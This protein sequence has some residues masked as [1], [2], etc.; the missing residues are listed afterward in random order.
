MPPQWITIKIASSDGSVASMTLHPPVGLVNLPK[1]DWILSDSGR[2][3]EL[4]DRAEDPEIKRR[5]AAEE[6]Y[7]HQT[8]IRDKKLMEITKPDGG[9]EYTWFGVKASRHDALDVARKR[10]EAEKKAAKVAF[11]TARSLP[12]EPPQAVSKRD[13]DYKKIQKEI[14]LWNQAIREHF[15]FT[16]TVLDHLD[17]QYRKFEEELQRYR[18]VAYP[19]IQEFVSKEILPNHV[20]T[21]ADN[22]KQKTFLKGKTVHGAFA[23][24]IAAVRNLRVH[25]KDTLDPKAQGELLKKIPV[26]EVPTGAKAAAGSSSSEPPKGGPGGKPAWGDIPPGG[27]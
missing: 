26:I 11:L 13:K 23:T 9:T 20:T 15:K 7:Y 19:K 6:Y 12:V 16:D 17:T 14:H 25:E 24:I 2:V 18:A 10:H 22:D 4:R 27:Q 3:S 1:D 5:K 21:Y 8:A